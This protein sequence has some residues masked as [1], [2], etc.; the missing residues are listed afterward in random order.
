MAM[1]VSFNTSNDFRDK[2]HKKQNP[3]H[4][5]KAGSQYSMFSEQ[6][7]KGKK[8]DVLDPLASVNI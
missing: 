4:K 7:E 1:K 5:R 8:W 3:K 2:Q 6:T